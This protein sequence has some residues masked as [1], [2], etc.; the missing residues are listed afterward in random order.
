MNKPE[1]PVAGGYLHLLL[2]SCSRQ[3][4]P[5]LGEAQCSA[6]A[7]G[8]PDAWARSCCHGSALATRPACPRPA[9]P[10]PADDKT[11]AGLYV[12]PRL[13]EAVG[14]CTAAFARCMLAGQ[15][16]PGVWFPEERGALGDRRALLGAA[17][18]G[19]AR[20]LVNRPTWSLETEPI[21]LGLGFYL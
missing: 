6:W 19:A 7:A 16:A 13:S 2:A 10:A 18:Q 11:A 15:T 3:S 14:T 5:V 4:G 20:F 21:Q 9:P 1:L 8:D 12:H 17:S